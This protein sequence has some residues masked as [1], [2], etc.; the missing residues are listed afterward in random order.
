MPYERNLPEL[1]SEPPL[2]IH[3]IAFTAAYS[4]SR[5]KIVA[6]WELIYQAPELVC[7]VNASE[8]NSFEIVLFYGVQISLGGKFIFQRSLVGKYGKNGE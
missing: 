3:S 8:R 1:S 2:P 7:G 4:L 6:R 5:R